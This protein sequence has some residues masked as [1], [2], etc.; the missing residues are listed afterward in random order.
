MCLRR[1]TPYFKCENT[2]LK[3][4]VQYAKNFIVIKPFTF[5]NYIK[6]YFF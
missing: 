2:A 1:E 5:E 3:I 6:P 4:S